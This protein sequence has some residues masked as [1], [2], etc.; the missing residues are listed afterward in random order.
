MELVLLDHSYAPNQR[1]LLDTSCDNGPPRNGPCHFSYHR[2]RQRRL[3]PHYGVNSL[4][5]KISYGAQINFITTYYSKN[6]PRMTVLAPYPNYL[7]IGFLLEDRSHGRVNQPFW[8]ERR[9]RRR[10][11]TRVLDNRHIRR[12]RI[13]G[14]LQVLSQA[15]QV[16]RTEF[17]QHRP[18]LPR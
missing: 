14:F 17:V 9:G 2:T 3:R 6:L 12:R 4:R 5:G 16:A 18:V 13:R 10:R 15:V 1:L 7:A 11:R 8:L